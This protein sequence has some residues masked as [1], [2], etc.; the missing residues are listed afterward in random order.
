M[1]IRQSIKISMRYVSKNDM[2]MTCWSYQTKTLMHALFIQGWHESVELNALH[3]LLRF[4]PRLHD[5]VKPAKNA[6]YSKFIN[7]KLFV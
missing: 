1:V 5:V 2:Q 4:E 7:L 6:Y 3:N